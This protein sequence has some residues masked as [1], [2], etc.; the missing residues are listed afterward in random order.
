[1]NLDD[2]IALIIFLI[3]APWVFLTNKILNLTKYHFR[4]NR[5]VIILPK[6]SSFES[7]VKAYPLGIAPIREINNLHWPIE[8]TVGKEE[9]N[10]YYLWP[11]DI[12]VV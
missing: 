9:I 3:V 2:F 8:V 12:K 7:F 6:S 11:E 5:L 1:M 4:K 10:L